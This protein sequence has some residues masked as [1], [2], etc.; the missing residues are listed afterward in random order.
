TFAGEQTP[1]MR[2]AK[3]ALAFTLAETLITLAIIGVVAAMT[4]PAV[5]N[6]TKET[7]L[8]TGLKKAQ[9]IIGSALQMMQYDTGIV[10]TH[11][12]YP[13]NTGFSEIFATYLL[14]ISDCSDKSCYVGSNERTELAKI[15]HTYNNASYIYSN[16]LDDGRMILLDGMQY[17][18]ED[19]SYLFITVDINGP[20]T[21]PDKWGHDLFTFE[22]DNETGALLPMG[23]PDTTY[24]SSS[25]CSKTSSNS[26]NGI[27]CTYKA[28]SEDDYFKNLP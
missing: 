19:C 16:F 7:Q 23:A 9:S 21:K 20:G 15:Y 18:V 12:N 10:A 24:S 25:Y 26:L 13:C 5:L 2:S 8:K 1:H 14:N 17:Y 27:S 22:I 11:E 6:H 3:L 28:L 4:I